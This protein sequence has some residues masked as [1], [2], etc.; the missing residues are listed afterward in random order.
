[1]NDAQRISTQAADGPDQVRRNGVAP[2]KCIQ[3]NKDIVDS[4]WFCRLPKHAPD[5]SRS[6]RQAILPQGTDPLNLQPLQADFSTTRA[7]PPRPEGAFDPN[8]AK[9]TLCS[10]ACALRYFASL[11][12]N[13]NGED[14]DPD[15]YERLL[16]FFID[17]EK[18]SWL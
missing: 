10:P 1:M 16:G 11:R 4:Q 14:P 17:G 3:C 12:A 7:N 8:A 9:V 13:G 2:S 6:S 18:P 15:R 5:D